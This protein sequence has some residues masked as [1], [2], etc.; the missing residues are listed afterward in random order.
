M[1]VLG[2]S[3]SKHGHDVREDDTGSVILISVE[4][5]AESFELVH[6]T[7]YRTGGGAVLGDPE[8]KTVAVQVTVAMY[9]EFKFDFP[10]C[11]GQWETGPEPAGLMLTVGRYSDVPVLQ[12][13]LVRIELLP[14]ARDSIELGF[15]LI[16]SY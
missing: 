11:G 1:I 15:V 16:S 14:V 2:I 12:Q 4:E 13:H 3:I 9:A 10:V 6:G 5:D 7:E 8:G